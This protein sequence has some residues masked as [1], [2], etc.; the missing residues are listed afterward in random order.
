MTRLRQACIRILAACESVIDA[1]WTRLNPTAEEY[2]PP[3]SDSLDDEILV[4][5]GAIFVSDKA[6]TEYRLAQIAELTWRL[7]YRRHEYA[8]HGC[9]AY[10]R[11]GNTYDLV[12]MPGPKGSES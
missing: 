9:Q 7:N 2:L 4:E 3:T 6:S 8:A 11:D 5:D 10:E 12:L 1:A